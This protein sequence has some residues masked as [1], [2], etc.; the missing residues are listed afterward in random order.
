MPNARPPKEPIEDVFRQVS[1][2]SL[3]E[4]SKMRHKS[5]RWVLIV[6]LIIIGVWGSILLLAYFITVPTMAEVKELIGDQVDW[7]EIYSD[8]V[9]AHNSKFS[10][11]AQVTLILIIPVFSTLA[12][13]YIRGGDD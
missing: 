13:S 4:P 5:I 2:E 10:S 3:D 8:I 9:A 6:L 1:P 11:L 12:G 7:I